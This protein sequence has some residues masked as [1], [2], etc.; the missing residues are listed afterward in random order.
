[1]H[2]KTLHERKLADGDAAQ[3]ELFTNM[4]ALGDREAQEIVQR[5]PDLL[6]R[7]GGYN[8][9]VLT[10]QNPNMSHL[11]VG[12]EGTLAFFQRIHLKLQPL[13]VH[14]TLGVCHFPSFYEAME[15]TQHIVELN[16]SAVEPVSYTHLTLPTIYSV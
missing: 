7:V 5:F 13:P 12:S 2:F 3:I 1:M 16:P 4:L 10:Q 9:D 15:A 14:K 6:R 11:L 8:I